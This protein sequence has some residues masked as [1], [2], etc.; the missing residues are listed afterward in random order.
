[1]LRAIKAFFD[2]QLLSSVA[3]DGDDHRLKLASAALLIEMMYQ[4]EDAHEAEQKV[5]KQSLQNKFGLSSEETETLFTLAHEE[6]QSATDYHQFTSLIA[7][8][9]SQDKKIKLIEYLWAVAYADGVLDKYE[10]HMVRRIADLIHISH[11]D[12][13]RTKHKHEK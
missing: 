2:S 8:N 6:R 5:I 11:K 1:M 13:M 3:D 12:F 9:F 10:E 7:K 4:D